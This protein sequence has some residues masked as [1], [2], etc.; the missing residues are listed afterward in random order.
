MTFLK[1]PTQKEIREVIR[2]LYEASPFKRDH[3]VVIKS[4]SKDIGQRE[5]QN[6]ITP[7]IPMLRK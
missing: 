5:L 3:P 2:E 6:D 7:V 4:G 1:C